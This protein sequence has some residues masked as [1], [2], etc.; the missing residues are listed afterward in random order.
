VCGGEHSDLREK[1]CRTQHQAGELLETIG[2]ASDMN[3]TE[4]MVAEASKG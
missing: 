2:N 1:I 3:V 4:A